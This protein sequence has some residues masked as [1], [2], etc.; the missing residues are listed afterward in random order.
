M[1]LGVYRSVIQANCVGMENFFSSQVFR[2]LTHLGLEVVN[3]R[4]EEV[5]AEFRLACSVDVMTMTATAYEK[6]IET[7]YVECDCDCVAC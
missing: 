4:A 2:L 5:V 3:V 6:M 1:G 7:C